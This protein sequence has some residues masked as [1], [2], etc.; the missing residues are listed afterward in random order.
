MMKRLRYI[1]LKKLKKVLGI[2]QQ[3]GDIEDE[4]PEGTYVIGCSA[5]AAGKIAGVL[6]R[7]G[8]PGTEN[9]PTNSP[10]KSNVYRK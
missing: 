8:Y 5:S 9:S 7:E 2:Q 4:F 10:D 3:F 6:D 1:W